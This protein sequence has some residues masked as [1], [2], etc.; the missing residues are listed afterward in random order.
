[1]RRATRDPAAQ[2]TR[3]GMSMSRPPTILVD[4]DP[5]G[6]QSTALHTLAAWH[7]ERRVE[8]VARTPAPMRA[9]D[10]ILEQLRGLLFPDL[11][12]A[13]ALAN[14][15]QASKLQLLAVAVE[16][17]IEFLVTEDASLHRLE[18]ELLDRYEVHVLRPDDLI[19]LVQAIE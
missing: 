11:S 16:R 17:R 2:L 18:E 9:D 15:E 7:E 5:L 14:E 3:Y 12:L 4:A 10:A 13:A 8:L 6:A 1:M 19:A